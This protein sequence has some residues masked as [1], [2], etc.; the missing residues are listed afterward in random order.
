MECLNLLELFKHLYFVRYIYTTRNENDG[1]SIFQ[2]Q[3][4]IHHLWVWVV[5]K[6]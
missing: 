1:I 2:I 4:Q 3:M 5:Q 6:Q